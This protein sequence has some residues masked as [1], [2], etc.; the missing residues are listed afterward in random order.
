MASIY[1]KQALIDTD[2]V[3]PNLAQGALL[4]GAQTDAYDDADGV[5]WVRYFGISNEALDA[6]LAVEVAPGYTLGG[7]L[8]NV[9]CPWKHEEWYKGYYLEVVNL[10][11]PAFPETFNEDDDGN[12]SSVTW[13][14]IAERPSV[15][16][17]VRDGRTFFPAGSVG[18]TGSRMHIDD[19]NEA[20][21]EGLLLFQAHELPATTE[22]E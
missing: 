12:V 20:V 9:G 15:A 22:S 11:A 5:A 19:F 16:P 10:D 4:K 1:L 13:R 17:I 18:G 14:Q 21:V 2:P 8:T 3:L 6:N 7:Y